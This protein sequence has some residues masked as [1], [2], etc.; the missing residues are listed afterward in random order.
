MAR[1]AQLCHHH[2]MLDTSTIELRE[3][4]DIATSLA[5]MAETSTDESEKTTLLTNLRFLLNLADDAIAREIP[6]H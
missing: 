6:V 1:P 4:M 3:L 2:A 5:D